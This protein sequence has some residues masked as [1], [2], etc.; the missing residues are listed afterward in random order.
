MRVGSAEQQNQAA[1]VL[2]EFM[3]VGEKCLQRYSR[4]EAYWATGGGVCVWKRAEIKGCFH[5]KKRRS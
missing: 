5:F 2:L 4:Y 3:K 1:R